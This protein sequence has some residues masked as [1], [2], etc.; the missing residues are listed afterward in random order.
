MATPSAYK[1]HSKKTVAAA[2]RAVAYK[3]VWRTAAF[4][5]SYYIIMWNDD[6][7]G[8]L[9]ASGGGAQ[10]SAEAPKRDWVSTL[11]LIAALLHGGQ[12]IAVAALYERLGG[13]TSQFFEGGRLRVFRT[14]W[15]TT[16]TP[17]SN[18]SG[19]SGSS[20]LSNNNHSVWEGEYTLVSYGTLDIRACILAFFVLS[21]VFQGAASWLSDG[22]SGIWRYVEY[23]FSAS[24]MA[25]AIAAEAG[26][27]DLYALV[28]V[29]GLIWATMAFGIVA[30]W[31]SLLMRG[32]FLWVVPHLAGWATCIAAYGSIL[33]SFNFNASRGSPPDFV[34]VI[35]FLQFG[36]FTCFGF[37]QAWGLAR[38]TYASAPSSSANLG[39]EEQ[40]LML[41]RDM[42]YNA[43]HGIK[44]DDD[45]EDGVELVFIGL[46]LTAK[47][48]LCWIVLSPLLMGD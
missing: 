46:S 32:T 42:Q 15:N 24:T 6:S 4:H 45:D 38:R 47:T 26:I 39:A 44:D 37:V 27:R 5:P 18:H 35:V 33:D 30:D 17:A 28:G 8:F 40:A 10:L 36:L 31:T 41:A 2:P 22:R 21:A 23:S 19:G 12:A 34:R 1:T 14:A 9:S 7:R 25:L 3:S 20:G 11:N 29:F 16:R 48:L 13:S 43:T